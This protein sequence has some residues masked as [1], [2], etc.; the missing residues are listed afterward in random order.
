MFHSWNQAF[1]TTGFLRCPN[2]YPTWWW[3]QCEGWLI[4]PHYEFPIIRCQALWSKH[5]LLHFLAL[6]SVVRGSTIAALPW[7][8]VLWSYCH[9][10][11]VE[12]A[13]RWIIISAVTFV[14]VLVWFI[15]TIL[16][17]VRQSISLSLGF[18]PLFLLGDDVLPWFVCRHNLGNCCSGHT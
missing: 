15:D 14:V 18:W 9:P 8:L 13:S 4:W 10:V 2:R 16:Y 1:I 11:F 7:M 17:N 12:T 3:E 5:H 6:F